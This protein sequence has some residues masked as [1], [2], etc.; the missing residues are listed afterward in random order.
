[1]CDKESSPADA[2]EIL[3]LISLDFETPAVS[4]SINYGS[5][6]PGSSNISPIYLLDGVPTVSWLEVFNHGNVITD[7]FVSGQD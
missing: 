7:I 4:R 3:S 2:P 6:A 1:M 5:L